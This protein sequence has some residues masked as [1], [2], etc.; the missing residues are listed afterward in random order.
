MNLALAT[1]K[2]A[3]SLLA[4]YLPISRLVSAPSLTNGN[5][6]VW[7]K[8]E[9]DL[10]TGSF[11][12][13][14]AL[15]ALSVTMSRGP[16]KEVIASSTGNH[17]AAVAFAAKMMGVPCTIF[18]PRNPNKTKRD[19]IAALG[20]KIVESGG[21]DLAAAFLQAQEYGRQE[22]VYFLND[23]TDPDLPAGP[24]TIALE[25]FEQNPSIH[26]IYVPM[27]DTALI[28][29]V[30]ATAK[31]LT[32][33]VRII[34]VQAERAPSYFLSWQEGRAISTETCDTIADGLA[35]RTPELENVRQIRELVDDVVLVSEDEMMAA[36]RYLKA[37]EGVLAEPAGAA[38][39]AAFL[40]SAPE[41]PSHVALLV[42]GSNISPEVQRAVLG[43]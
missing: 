2:E 22:G 36:I 29:G 6:D 11:K 35:T 17:G 23:A 18:L 9:T 7:L 10:P 30:A 19:K 32:Q 37:K 14:G 21:A 43:G 34:G 16:V 27:G 4:R 41:D 3:K 24:G 42:T 20:A 15:W 28:R 33:S 13:R 40:K 39:T 1:V 26:T 12:P 31:Q 25:I 5:C 8:S 38:A